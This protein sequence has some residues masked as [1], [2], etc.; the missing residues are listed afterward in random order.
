[1]QARPR[2]R[3]GPGALPWTIRPPPADPAAPPLAAGGSPGADGLP[4]ADGPPAARS[5]EP[6]T[7]PRGLRDQLK[8]TRDAAIALVLAHVELAK[9]EAGSIAGEVGRVAALGVLAFLLIVF[10]VFLFVIGL[11][12][13]IGEWVLGSMGWG[14]LHGVLLFVS[15]AMAAVL[16]GL[17]ISA[18]R[19]VGAFAVAVV[20]AIVVGVLLGL[21][22]P[23]Q[24]YA[25]IGD[26]LGVAVDPGIRPLVVGMLLGGFVG[27][28]AGL[29]AAVTMNASGGGRFV[30]LAGLT[31]LG[32][33]LG[34]FTAI[35]FGPQVGAG[36]GIAVGYITWIALMAIDVARTGIDVEALKRRFY[37]VQTIDT[38][39]ET[40]EWLQKRM[41][42]GIGS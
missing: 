28:L 15:L 21:S 14:I 41:P 11:S 22:L 26:A 6:R 8:S 29:A 42:P 10:A 7:A 27:L 30:A 25:S 39:K 12:L 38:S 20:V 1:M 34:A 19:V 3:T 40:L 37:P 36:I 2:A 13:G 33:A 16:I 18:R 35:T 24:L 5:R 9:A 4:A 23:N 17:G 31:V 32:V